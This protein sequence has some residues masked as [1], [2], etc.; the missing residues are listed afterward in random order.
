MS[1]EMSC[2]FKKETDL[3][4]L[5]HDPASGEDI[6]IPLS[7]VESMHGRQRDGTG[8]GTI[9]MSDWIAEQ[10]GLI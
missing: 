6:W 9:V 10:K 7:Q 4:V 2:E 1:H 8:H 3:A 5:I